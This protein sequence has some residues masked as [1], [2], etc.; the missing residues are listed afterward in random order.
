[1]GPV[2]WAFD[3][4]PNAFLLQCALGRDRSESLLDSLRDFFS[5]S[6]VIGGR[7]LAAAKRGE[8]RST[9]VDATE[10]GVDRRRPIFRRL[11]HPDEVILGFSRLRQI[12]TQAVYVELDATDAFERRDDMFFKLH[13]DEL[14]HVVRNFSV[15]L[16]GHMQ[17]CRFAAVLISYEFKPL[18]ECEAASV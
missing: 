16:V 18:H 2:R 15:C 5:Q 1:M 11:Q 6:P 17:H 10:I 14:A 9:V 3:N 12:L 8:D 13:N 7:V 4:E